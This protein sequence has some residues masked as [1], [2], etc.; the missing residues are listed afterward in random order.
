[1]KNTITFVSVTAN[2]ATITTATP[3]GYQLTYNGD[4]AVV[5]V[6]GLANSFLNNIWVL[7][8]VTNNSFSFSVSHVDLI[9][10]A[11]S[12]QAI[13]YS[14]E[15]LRPSD[16]KD[17][18]EY[19]DNGR[20]LIDDP[21]KIG[22]EG[23]AASVL[24]QALARAVRTVIPA[25]TSRTAAIDGV[26]RGIYTARAPSILFPSVS[27]LPNACLKPI[28]LQ[29]SGFLTAKSVTFGGVPARYFEVISDSHIR[30]NPF[31]VNTAGSKP[32]V[33]TTAAN[34][35]QSPATATTAFTITKPSSF[36]MS[37]KTEYLR[38]NSPGIGALVNIAQAH[39]NDIV[40]IDGNSSGTGILWKTSKAGTAVRISGTGLPT[41]YPSISHTLSSLLVS[42]NGGYSTGE[43]HGGYFNTKYY[44]NNAEAIITANQ[45]V[46]EQPYPGPDFQGFVIG[47]DGNEYYIGGTDYSQPSAR[48]YIWRKNPIN[49]LDPELVVVDDCSFGPLAISMP[50]GYIL[51]YD[52][53]NAHFASI[54]TSFN[55]TPLAA[56]PNITFIQSGFV[57]ADGNVFCSG[58]SASFAYF[59]IKFNPNNIAG[60]VVIPIPGSAAFANGCCL[61]SDGLGY[62]IGGNF[63]T[64][65]DS[66]L[67]QYNSSLTL[68]NTATLTGSSS[69]NSNP[70]FARD[71]CNGDDSNIWVGIGVEQGASHNGSIWKIGGN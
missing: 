34:P 3:H 56:I 62:F 58:L 8:A 55:I 21:A 2:V 6:Q 66:V 23:I 51:A 38:G 29:G 35:G 31:A 32:I 44:G 43:H 53:K 22:S 49:T 54:D 63:V 16:L 17:A 30:C 5:A 48:G 47:P 20:I 39:D 71:L 69:S 50:G 25:G 11:D 24:A 40:F 70:S 19:P 28:L 60:A 61:G 18:T 27:S 59:F 9:T 65:V 14:S 68:L 12:G 42:P 7:I 46:T 36:S 45:F 4:N 10:T 26:E 52:S 41:G 57:D 33:V 64:N 67:F 1:M 13:L 15:A 37:S